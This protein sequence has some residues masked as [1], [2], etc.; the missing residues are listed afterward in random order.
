M[1][2][3]ALIAFVIIDFAV[4]AFVFGKPS[5]LALTL[6]GMWSAVRIVIQIGDVL[7]GPSLGLSY[8]QFASYLFDPVYA[9]PPNPTGIPGA[10]IDLIL[11]LEV[12]VIWL[13]WKARS[14]ARKP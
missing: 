3:Y 1:H 12:I 7:L 14:S 11:I 13:M 2:G 6:A 5:S 8:A 10:P 4:G 9:N